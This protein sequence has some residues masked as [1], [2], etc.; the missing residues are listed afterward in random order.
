MSSP[1]IIFNIFFWHLYFYLANTQAYCVLFHNP[2]AIYEGISHWHV[3]TFLADAHA[4]TLVFA[5][6]CQMMNTSMPL[7]TF[8]L[9]MPPHFIFSFSYSTLRICITT[10]IKLRICITT[11]H[12]R[13]APFRIHLLHLK[14]FHKRMLHTTMHCF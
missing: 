8:R 2:L 9:P 7:L 12:I 4:R 13:S 6:Q 5:G 10:Y 14:I 11:L 1:C 3:C